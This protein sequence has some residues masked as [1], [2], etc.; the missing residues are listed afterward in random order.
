M[1]SEYDITPRK[2]IEHE[3]RAKTN[4]QRAILDSA[5]QIIISTNAN[6]AIESLNEFAIEL[7]GWQPYELVHKSSMDVF[8]R[9]AEYQNLNIVLIKVKVLFMVLKL[10]LF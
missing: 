9:R 5:Q 2:L 4:L 1:L 7:L 3:L 8:I 10:N 6:G